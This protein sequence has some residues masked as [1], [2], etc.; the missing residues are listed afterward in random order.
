MTGNE[1]ETRISRD[2]LLTNIMIFWLT[3]TIGSSI[4]V[5]YANAHAAPSPKAGQRP[6]VPAGVAHDPH[7]EPLPRE[8]AERKVNLKH[9]T[10]LPRGGHFV[11]WEAPDLYAA[12]VQD[13]VRQLSQ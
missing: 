8:W 4:R 1:S 10:V 2:E 11:A 3:E 12:D 6:S 7:G 9:F 5:Y 13:F